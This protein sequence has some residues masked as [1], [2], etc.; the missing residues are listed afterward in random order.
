MAKLN[1]FLKE[2]K[3]EFSRINW[4]SKQEATRMVLIVIAMSVIVSLFLGVF[5]YLFTGFIK[6]ILS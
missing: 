5:D 3:Q 6:N 4:P 2:S 1:N